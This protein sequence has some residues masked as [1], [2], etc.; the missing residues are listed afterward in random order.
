MQRSAGIVLVLAAAGVFAGAS[1]DEPGA[2]DLPDSPA[3]VAPEAIIAAREALMV[4]AEE[5]M[6]PIDTYTVD[7]SIDPD[8]MRTNANAISAMLLAL[9]N[10]FPKSTDLYDPNVE[11][12]ATLA[13]PAIWESFA[14]FYGLASAA[15]SAATKLADSFDANELNAASL[16][17][18]ASCDA[19]HSV[20]LLPYEEPK[21][22]QEERDF[23]FDSIF[24]DE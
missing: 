14:S 13:L 10:L 8:L 18:R 1:A 17:L 23:D 6:K 11:S 5:L 7:D 15:S 21:V 19:C 16:G 24:G 12:P 22:T 2:G 4:Q 20:Y 9:P 3:D